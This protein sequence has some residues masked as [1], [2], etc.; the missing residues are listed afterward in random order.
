MATVNMLYTCT[1]GYKNEKP[2]DDDDDDG[3]VDGGGFLLSTLSAV[4]MP[5]GFLGYQQ[6]FF[7]FLP[8]QRWYF[9]LC[10]VFIVDLW[11]HSTQ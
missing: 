7:Y 2:N 9:Y 8:W 6:Y 5:F 11:T 10:I 1:A 4:D 3:E